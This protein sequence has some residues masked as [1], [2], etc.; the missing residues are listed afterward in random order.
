[1]CVDFGGLLGRYISGTD[2][3]HSKHSKFKGVYAFG[4]FQYGSG[5]LQLVWM[6]AYAGIVPTYI[7]TYKHIH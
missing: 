1:M 4:T 2:L 3:G 6:A 7:Y 5:R